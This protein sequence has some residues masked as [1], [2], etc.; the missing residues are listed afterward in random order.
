MSHSCHDRG[1]KVAFR[2]PASMPDRT[3]RALTG[4][5]LVKFRIGGHTGVARISVVFLD[6]DVLRTFNASG[7]HYLGFFLV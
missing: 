2:Q 1:A 7:L 5:N 4:E 6:D 3:A